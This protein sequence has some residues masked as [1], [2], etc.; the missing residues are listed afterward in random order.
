MIEL[1]VE[2][3]GYEGPIVFDDSKPDGTPRK[4]LD[5]SKMNSMGWSLILI[6]SAG[7]QMLMMISL[8]RHRHAIT[9]KDCMMMSRKKCYQ[10][11]NRKKIYSNTVYDVFSDDLSDSIGNMVDGY[12]SVEAKVTSLSPSRAYVCFCLKRLNWL[13]QI[14][15][16]TLWEGLA[17]KR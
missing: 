2:V 4:F 10:L 17:M 15:T 13:Y 7:L 16:D 1:I 6:W 14:S 3:I 5:V 9:S 11:K 12:L 8:K